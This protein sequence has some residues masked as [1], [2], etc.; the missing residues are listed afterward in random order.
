MKSKVDPVEAARLYDQGRSWAEVGRI[1]AQLN[2]RKT[3]YHGEYIRQVVRRY[4]RR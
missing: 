3:P 4:D 1:I 2:Q